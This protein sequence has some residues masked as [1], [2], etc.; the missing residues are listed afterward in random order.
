MSFELWHNKG[1]GFGFVHDPKDHGREPVKKFLGYEG[2]IALD[3]SADIDLRPWGP[4]VSDQSI[5]SGCVPSAMGTSIHGTALGRNITIAPW[6]PDSTISQD[7]LYKAT[8]IMER[9]ASQS[10]LD[11]NQFPPLLDQGSMPIM[12][13]QAVS[14]IG[15][16]ARKKLD[17]DDRNSD[18]D[19]FTVNDEPKFGEL[20]EEAKT[21]VVGE[22]FIDQTDSDYLAQL[23]AVLRSRIWIPIATYADTAFQKWD[24]S[25]GPIPAPNFNDPHGGGHMVAL[26]GG[27]ILSSGKV[28]GIIQNS[29]GSKRWGVNGY[30]E[31]SENW[32]LAT[33]NAIALTI[34]TTS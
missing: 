7:A 28:T 3:S 8:R 20:E 17:P 15:I 34:R 25:T 29:W 19:P 14:K 16:K 4:P 5:T 22:Y 6:F 30:G 18:L 12:C 13:G 31:V 33:S 32:L 26:C 24:P 21:L 9:S 11:G 1:P 2:E 23:F 27:R 10:V